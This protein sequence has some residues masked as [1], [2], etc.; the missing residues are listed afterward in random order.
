MKKFTTLLLALLLTFSFAACSKP[1]EPAEPQ[2]PENQN[3]ENE[4]E[5]AVSD[6]EYVKN[7]GTLIVGITDFEPMDYKAPSGEWIGFDADMAKEFAKTLGVE[8]EFI[9]IDWD[10]KVFELENKSIDCVWN[11]MTLNE[12][13]YNTMECSLPYCNNAQ[14]VVVK[15]DNANVE[16][17]STL[18]FACENGSAG[19]EALDAL[20]NVEYTAVLTQADALMEVAAG[21]SDACVI[22]LLMAAAMI[23]EGTAYPDLVYTKELTSEKYGVGFRKG[24]DLCQEYNEFYNMFFCADKVRAVASKYGVQA[25]IINEY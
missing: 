6:L 14:V 5:T 11:G 22:D 15:K 20:G 23:G 7:K 3:T 24:S 19:Q 1:Q 21:T 9:E 17:L 2:Q 8:V 25:S 12:G 16:D 10:N 18:A 4:P 13:T